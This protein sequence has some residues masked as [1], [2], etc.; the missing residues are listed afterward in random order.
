[1]T[2]KFGILLRNPYLTMV[3]SQNKE[4]TTIFVSFGEETGK[5]RRERAKGLGSP[6]ARE[7]WKF[8][9]KF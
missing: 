8:K 3:K 9:T 6:I 4:G 7:S 1:M 2:F 5:E